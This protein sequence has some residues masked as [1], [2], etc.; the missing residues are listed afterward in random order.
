MSIRFRHPLITIDTHSLA[1]MTYFGFIRVMLHMV[2]LHYGGCDLGIRWIQKKK[3]QVCVCVCA[4]RGNDALEF[5]AQGSELE[6]RSVPRQWLQGAHG[7]IDRRPCCNMPHLPFFFGCTFLFYPVSTW[8]RVF[9]SS[10]CIRLVGVCGTSVACRC[11]FRV[12]Q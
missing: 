11:E 12:P 6:E 10:V 7:I 8:Q 4:G 9:L 2:G 5:A 1:W 3:I